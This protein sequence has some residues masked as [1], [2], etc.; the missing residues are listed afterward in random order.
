[1]ANQKSCPGTEELAALVDGK[2]SEPDRARILEHID[3]CESCL[4]DLTDTA[5]FLEE[6]SSPQKG[7]RGWR[8]GRKWFYLGLAAAAVLL[9]A[10]F[11]IPAMLDLT[12]GGPPRLPDSAGLLRPVLVEVAAVDLA[13]RIDLGGSLG[14]APNSSLEAGAF[15][16]GVLIVDLRLAALAD[17]P[18]LVD[19]LAAS[20][21]RLS[22]DFPNQGLTAE[23]TGLRDQL[24][25]GGG[26]PA[27]YLE[28]ISALESL[29]KGRSA[30]E[31][32]FQLGKWTETARLGVAA[33]QARILAEPVMRDFLDSSIGRLDRN[34]ATGQQLVKIRLLARRE[35]SGSDPALL[36][37]LSDF[38]RSF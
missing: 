21:Q 6:H 19:Q 33:G 9:V 11:Q 29:A 5:Q 28:S 8:P 31:F 23:W 3:S 25:S 30:R 10:I 35:V 36:Q 32:H 38:R 2:L 16:L 37:A 18:L 17:D 13:S 12:S 26:S 4:A 7:A 20:G 22:Q 14:F 24:P 27:R 34:S 1:M 15:R